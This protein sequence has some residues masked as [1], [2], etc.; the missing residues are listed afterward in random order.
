MTPAVRVRVCVC[1]CV[2]VL[3]C[4][5]CVAMQCEDELVWAHP[6]DV[7][8]SVSTLDDWPLLLVSVWQQDE[9][10]RHEIAGYGVARLPTCPGMHFM[11]IVT[12][13]PEGTRLQEIAAWFRGGLP[14]LTDTSVVTEADQRYLLRTISTGTV[15]VRGRAA[16]GGD[17]VRGP[18]A[19]RMCAALARATLPMQVEV[20][21]LLKG[22]EEHGVEFGGA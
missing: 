9:L 12:W 17:V 2:C 16:T 22:F 13:R 21:V 15:Q 11:D 8:Y 10:E 19:S 7:W 4:A 18:R 14:Q 5:L 6:L 3:R 1:V 20:Q